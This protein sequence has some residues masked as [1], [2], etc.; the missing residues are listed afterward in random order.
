[1]RKRTT[2]FGQFTVGILATGILATGILAAGFL[3]VLV[4]FTGC[5]REAEPPKVLIVG[6]DAADWA[7]M[8]PLL[9]QGRLP[10]FQHLIETGAHGPLWSLEPM[11]SPL[12]WTT[13]A[14]G[15]GPDVHG[16]LD[17]TMPDPNTGDPIVVSSNVRQSK[18][19]WNILSDRGIKTAVIGWWATW[20]AEPV[21]GII[22]SDRI[23]SHAFIPAAEA[24]Q[25]L[26]YP[27][28]M[29]EEILALTGDP[30]AVPYE[31]ARRFINVTPEEYAAAPE[32]DYSDPISH[33]RH[34]YQTMSDYAAIS[35]HLAE[36]ESPEVLA[37]YFEGVD[38][39][40]HMYMRYAPPEYPF[41]TAE[42]R[43]SYGGTVD[44]FYEYQDQIL[45]D[46]LALTDEGTH[47]FVVSDHGFKSGQ[48]RPIEK[49][50]EVDYAT[51]ATWHRMQGVI[52]MKGP[53]VR[54]KHT[55]SDPPAIYGGATVFDITPTL[56]TL[57]GLPV[58]EDMEGQV[59][60]EMLTTV[61]VD[62]IPSYEDEVWRENRLEASAHLQGIDAEM[63]E[64]LRSLGYIGADEDDEAL[65]LRGQW[66]LADY[67][68]FRERYEDAARELRALMDRAPD[69]AEPYYHMGLVYMRQQAHPKAREMFEKAL[70]LDPEKNPARMNLAFIY[71]ELGNR[72]KALEILEEAKRIQPRHVGTRINQGM[73]YK[74][75]RQYDE[76][77][78]CFEEALELD[79]TN[80]PAL[81]QLAMTY[82]LLKDLETAIGY[83]DRALQVRPNDQ[84]A[85]TRV[86]QARQMLEAHN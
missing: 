79:Q 42:Q 15:K 9:E 43:E 13:I 57:L 16:V 49:S 61:Q 53:L 41:T 35:A 24:E 77:V 2:A 85:Q 10:H 39:A 83:W 47:V 6:V 34:M 29:T 78:G 68:I 67:Y 60:T 72:R 64:K 36:T 51:A 26:V 65:S 30:T 55:E 28:E 66:S 33:F 80:H 7:I 8:R 20:P 63:K 38:T 82:E 86:Q 12:I 32:L 14:T 17:F 75:M 46:L 45:G 4:L 81:V 52:I 22:V 70:E 27:P 56:L 73:L 44:A 37:V 5:E 19:F 31:V 1:M 71:R 18:A 21:N 25:D 74:E 62:S 59:L 84:R 69:W 23:G 58:G 48:E 76:A 54:A 3:T 11:I 40:G 50:D